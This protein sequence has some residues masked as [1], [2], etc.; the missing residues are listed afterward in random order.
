VFRDAAGAV[1]ASA[2]LRLPE[3]LPAT[4][5]SFRGNWRLTSSKAGFP[6]AAPGSD[7]YE[8]EVRD[9]HVWI[10]LNPGVADSNVMLSG[11]VGDGALGGTWYYATIA[12]G[13]PMG[14][15]TVTPP[16]RTR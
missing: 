6:A 12:G 7:A 2:D 1:V 3:P 11:S 14:S 4:G 16:R 8:G 10:N 13:K 5:T 15:F 9:G